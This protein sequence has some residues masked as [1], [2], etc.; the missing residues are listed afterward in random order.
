MEGEIM[1]FPQF[2]NTNPRCPVCGA[3]NHIVYRVRTHDF[4]CKNAGC[5]TVFTRDGKI[6]SRE[7]LAM[8]A[9]HRSIDR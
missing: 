6:K 8:R 1:P 5:K 9:F 2:P 4:R 7:P 3:K